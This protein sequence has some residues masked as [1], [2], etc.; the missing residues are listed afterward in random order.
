MSEHAGFPRRKPRDRESIKRQDIAEVVAASARWQEKSRRPS[1]R[2]SETG[3]LVGRRSFIVGEGSVMWRLVV[4]APFEEDIELAVIDDEGVHALVFP[5]LRLPGGWANAL[6]G[7]LLDV[8][9]THWRSWPTQR[10]DT[11]DLH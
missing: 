7:E 6:T 2:H 8:H 11:S 10:C 3:P 9:P 4:E 1:D 5:C